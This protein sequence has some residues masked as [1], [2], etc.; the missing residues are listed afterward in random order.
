MSPSARHRLNLELQRQAYQR[1]QVKKF[2]IV[3]ALLGILSLLM[4]AVTSCTSADHQ[5][6]SRPAT[7]QLTERD[8]RD[9]R[10]RFVAPVHAVTGEPAATMQ[11]IYRTA[12]SAEMHG[13]VYRVRATEIPQL[14]EP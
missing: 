12:S 11:T 13:P 2:I 4:V 3:L 5:P 1:A 9:A 14:T 6:E 10:G 7:I 8:L